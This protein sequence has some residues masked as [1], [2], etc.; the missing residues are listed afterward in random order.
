MLALAAA[1]LGLKT[2]IY[3]DEDDAPAL[4]VAA[5][6]TIAAY[7]DEAALS[8]FVQTC[9]VV[10]FEFENVPSASLALLAHHRPTHP[11]ARALS[12]TQDRF[13]EKTFLSDLG[14]GTAQ[15]ARAD[16]IVEARAALSRIGA[17]AILKTRRLGYDG[18]GQAR[19]ARVADLKTAVASLREA[20][21]ILE[22]LV[23]FAFECS[24]VAARSADGAFAAY[25]PPE[26]LHGDH[27]LRRSQVPARLT[28]SQTGQVLATT[29]K[30][31]EA[32]GYVGVLAVEFF[33]TKNGELLVNEIAPRV[34]NSGHWTIEACVVSQ[35]E[36]HIRAV[37]GWP[38]GDPS[39]HSDAVM[40]NLV[41]SE[42][43]DWQQLA[44]DKG[45]LHL[46][47]KKEMRP[48][49]KLGHITRL[50]PLGGV[51]EQRGQRD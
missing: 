34:H 14:I 11:D 8:A 49:R 45:A 47:G 20:P 51:P 18:K 9:N 40:E 39:R 12:R 28:A 7:D 48:G 43:K 5:L 10:T 37:A 29:R 25:D 19:I 22:R 50:S 4:D 41:G 6:R 3:S 23:D 31:A 13:A 21:A 17:P 27:I 44:R 38:L 30:I 26:N 32:L 15:F 33:V 42:A 35:F 24:V 16:G 2:H 1:K 46:Y 36:Q